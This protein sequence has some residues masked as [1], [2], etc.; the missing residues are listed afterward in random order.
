MYFSALRR[1][2]VCI[3]ERSGTAA[4]GPRFRRLFP[5]DYVAAGVPVDLALLSRAAHLL[6]PGGVLGGWSAAELLGASCGPAGAPV[7][8]IAA[9]RLRS[10]PGLD[11][12]HCRLREDE[13]T[14]V[15][16]ISVTTGLRTAYDRAPPTCSTGRGGWLG[17]SVSTS[18]DHREMYLRALRR[19]LMYISRHLRTLSPTRWNSLRSE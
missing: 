1:A 10:R 18:G 15:D 4:R 17:R 7:D 19:A 6:A 5:N 12:R 2:L 3:W 14:E 16:G 9:I 8:I 11:V 13:I